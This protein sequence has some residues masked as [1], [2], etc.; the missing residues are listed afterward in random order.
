MLRTAASVAAATMALSILAPI[1]ASADTPAGT[2]VYHFSYSSQ[3]N[4][5]ARDSSTPAESVNTETESLN[6]AGGTNGMSTYQGQLNDKGTITVNIVRQQ[7]DGALV[8]MI[9]EQGEN[10][11]RAPPAECV[12]YGNTN[13]ICD[14]N[15]TVYTEEYTLLRFLGGNFVDPN[16]LDANRHWQIVQN[17]PTLDV[18]ANYTINSQSNGIMQIGESRSLRYPKGGS[19][20]TD[21]QSKIGYDFK[22]SL[23]I[24]V[25]E[26]TQQRLDNGAVGTTRTIYQTT[27]NLVSDSMAKT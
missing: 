1:G 15:K 25:D 19:L 13:V 12:V 6:T 26:Y 5:T 22:R 8:V 3:Q 21:I 10:V 17:T 24:S 23:P 9:S 14:P 11:H 16:A 20:T 4:I 2:L 18:T 27:L 7:P